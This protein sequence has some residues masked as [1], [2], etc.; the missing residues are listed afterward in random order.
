MSTWTEVEWGGE[1]RDRDGGEESREA[2]DKE[3]G[4]A[5]E[6]GV[7]RRGGA[8]RRGEQLPF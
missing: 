8:E 5:R 6:G 3:Q 7:R 2:K 4:R 1:R